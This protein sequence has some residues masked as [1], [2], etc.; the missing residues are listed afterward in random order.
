MTR[1][2]TVIVTGVGGGV[3]Q[4]IMKGLHL[5][6]DRRGEVE[7]R[8]IGVDAD[9]MAS[10]LF[11]ADVGY[12]VP[13]AHESGYVD[14][15]IEV[16]QEE[17]V[18][19]LVPGSDPEVSV[20]AKN[21]DT[22]SND[23]E[24]EILVSS[25]DSVD[26]GR[27][28]WRTYNFLKEHGFETPA[29]VLGSDA[30]DIVD[31][32]GFPL[33]VKPRTGSAS[34]GL[35]VVTD[36]NELNY[37]LT[38]STDEVVVQEYLVPTAWE[39]RDLTRSDLRRQVDEYS[40]ETIV[41]ADGDIVLSL[42][43]WRKMDKGV[44]SVAKIQPYDDIREA[45]EAVV[46]NLDVLGP[47]NLQARMTESGISFFELNTRF[48]GSTAVRCTAGF[49]GPDAMVRH[50]VLGDHINESDLSFENLVEMRYKDEVYVSEDTFEQMQTEGRVQGGG[51]SYEYF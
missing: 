23:G 28:K 34:R 41:D 31:S 6:M 17:N 50:L 42:S 33:I 7:Y 13:M 11:R 26:V 21:R 14:R 1:Q 15:L 39:G 12:T 4:S 51:R 22:L 25:A 29:T 49:N 19:I 45:C 20:V 36:Y 24:M 3:G 43:N 40:T 10:G 9:P 8:I 47:V 30:Y 35:F 44:P 2:V 5:A 18:D 27:D 46:D 32:V 48:T 37:A 38:Q 16:A